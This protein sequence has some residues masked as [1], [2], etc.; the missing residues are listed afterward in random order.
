MWEGRGGGTVGHCRPRGCLS[1]RRV[2]VHQNE[3]LGKKKR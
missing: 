3:M 2:V 1:S